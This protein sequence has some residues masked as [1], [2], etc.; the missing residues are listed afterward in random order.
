MGTRL[1]ECYLLLQTLPIIKTE[2]DMMQ[3]SFLNPEPDAVKSWV[4]TREAAKKRLED[5]T[6]RAGIAYAK[7]RNFDL[8]A[9]EHA[10]VSALSPWIRHRVILE[11][12]V[13]PVL[14]TSTVQKMKNSFKK[15]FGAVISKAG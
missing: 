12:D 9:K 7:R 6:P 13:K 2:N 3:S 10:N 14:W 5:F 11:E 15:C 4:P 1:G 8:G